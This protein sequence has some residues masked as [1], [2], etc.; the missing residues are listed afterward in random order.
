[1]INGDKS[2]GT[3]VKTF[4][5][6]KNSEVR[7]SAPSLK[8]MQPIKSAFFQQIRA[9]SSL[10]GDHKAR[11]RMERELIGKSIAPQIA[12]KTMHQIRY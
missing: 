1:T 9:L 5:A 3:G 4:V 12:E 10:T 11:E 6:A 2:P 8:P 7:V